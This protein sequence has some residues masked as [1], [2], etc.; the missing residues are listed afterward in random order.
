MLTTHCG[1]IIIGDEILTG[2]RQDAHFGFLRDTLTQAGVK[3]SR[4]T[5]VGDDAKDLL[6][7]LEQSRAWRIPVF[8]FGGIGATVDDRTRQLAAQAF[9]RPLTRHPEAA[10]MIY[11]QFGLSAEPNRILMADL[12]DGAQLI[13]NPLSQIPGF[14]VEQHFFLPGFPQMAHPM[15]AWCLIQRL[16]VIGHPVGESFALWVL[17]P[18][19][20]LVPIMAQLSEQFPQCH[21]FSLPDVRPNAPKEL[22]FRSANAQQQA[23]QALVQALEHARIPWAESP[24]G[25]PS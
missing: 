24:A 7:T 13:P 1:A 23:Q 4:V 15:L 12:P 22:G 11:D 21:F 5:Y 3:L 19:S 6:L 25:L 9:Q 20:E 8:S 2:R 14:Q 16:N 10:R 18:E 17:T